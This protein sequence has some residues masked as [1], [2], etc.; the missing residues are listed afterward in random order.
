MRAV[1]QKMGRDNFYEILLFIM[2]ESKNEKSFWKPYLD[3]LPQNFDHLPMYI[4]NY[5]VEFFGM[6]WLVDEIDAYTQKMDEGW[7]MVQ[8][9][10]LHEFPAIF[11][12]NIFSLENFQWAWHILDSRSIWMNGKRHLIPML[13]MINCCGDTK[14]LR[15]VK[16]A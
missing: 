13:D 7:E 1:K 3:I 10:I 9:R 15:A 11:D 4:V 16:C 12:K 5:K 14:T 2:A 6:K 8:D